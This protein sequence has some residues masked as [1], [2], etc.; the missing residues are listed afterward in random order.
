MR[1][2]ISEWMMII[3]IIVFIAIDELRLLTQYASGRFSV[4]TSC[5][6]VLFQIVVHCSTTVINY[7]KPQSWDEHDSFFQHNL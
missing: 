3:E 1:I 7:S 5:K 2:N 6:N 4:P